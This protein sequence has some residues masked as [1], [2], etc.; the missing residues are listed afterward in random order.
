MPNPVEGLLEVY[1][2]MVWPGGRGVQATDIGLKFGASPKSHHV[3]DSKSCPVRAETFT[4]YPTAKSTD[5]LNF[6]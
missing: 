6:L 5:R 3:D 2:D 4:G 1:E